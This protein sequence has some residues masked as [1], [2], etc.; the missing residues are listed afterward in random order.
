MNLTQPRL[1]P[2]RATHEVQLAPHELLTVNAAQ[3]S[4]IQ[5]IAGRVWVTVSGSVDDTFVE[6]GDHLAMPCNRGMVVIEALNETVSL[7][8]TASDDAPSI[9]QSPAHALAKGLRQMADWV[10]GMS[11]LRKPLNH[12]LPSHG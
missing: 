2:T 10:D 11:N 12:R 5:S 1:T 3:L 7:R 9:M 8:I 6:S 4:D